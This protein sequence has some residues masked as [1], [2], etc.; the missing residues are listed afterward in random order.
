VSSAAA[1]AQSGSDVSVI[2]SSRILS[3]GFSLANAKAIPSAL[4]EYDVH[5]SNRGFAALTRN[6]LVITNAVPA[7]LTLFA[8]DLDA[9]GSGPVV[10]AE[11]A[12]PSGLE[13]RFGGIADA[14]DCLEFSND[15]GLSFVYVPQPD[16]SGF[17]RAI[18]HI[19]MRPQGSMAPASLQPSSFILRY[20]MKVN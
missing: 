7:G 4:V 8:R 2:L 1:I 6:S 15:N 20:R 19:R 16:A 9:A 5:V 11:G 14:S 3:D 18:T 10:F 12:V 17:D 13:C